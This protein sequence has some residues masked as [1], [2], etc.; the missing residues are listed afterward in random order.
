MLFR[1][2]DLDGLF[3]G[4]GG[5]L[6]VSRLSIGP[7]PLPNLGQLDAQLSPDGK[8]H[9]LT[10]GAGLGIPVGSSPPIEI[11]TGASNTITLFSTRDLGDFFATYFD[12]EL[13]NILRQLPV[14][15]SA[16]W[17]TLPGW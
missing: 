3:V 11:H 1:S 5:S 8:V 13:E 16:P 15:P 14:P 17:R 10:C 9:E 4:A 6:L 7:R 2:H 12:R